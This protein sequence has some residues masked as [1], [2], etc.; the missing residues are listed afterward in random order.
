MGCTTSNGRGNNG[1]ACRGN[2]HSGRRG[3][4]YGH[5]HIFSVENLKTLCMKKVSFMD[6]AVCLNCH[7]FIIWEFIRRYGYTAGVTKDKYGRGYVEAKLCNGWVDKLAK[8]VAAQDFTYKQPIN[9]RQYLIR[10]EA[11]LAEEK[12]NEQDIS[13]TY[14]IDPDGRIKRVSTFKNGTVQT[15]YWCRSSL[16]WKLT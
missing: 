11:R 7:V 13:R 10:D 9:K 14:G 16:G 5:R 8:Y 4:L 6:I 2:S 1:I 12:R 3:N 15:W